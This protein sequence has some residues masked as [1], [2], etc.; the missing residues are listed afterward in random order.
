MA[1]YD[2]YNTYNTLDGKVDYCEVS[3]GDHKW[4]PRNTSNLERKEEPCYNC[5]SEVNNRFNYTTPYH[6]C[7]TCYRAI[8]MDCN[9]GYG[10]YAG[11][12]FT[13]YIAETQRGGRPR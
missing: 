11:L 10:N 2:S 3:G 5:K 1:P 13:T 12:N 6:K 9:H 8:C 7:T 4:N